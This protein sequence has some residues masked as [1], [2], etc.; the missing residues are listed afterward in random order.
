MEEKRH[1][2][3]IVSSRSLQ[4]LRILQETC[5][6]DCLFMTEPNAY[7]VITTKT[8]AEQLKTDNDWVEKVELFPIYN[9]RAVVDE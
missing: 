9:V 2:R 1:Y 5:G 6:K 8:I 4:R 7:I 3:T